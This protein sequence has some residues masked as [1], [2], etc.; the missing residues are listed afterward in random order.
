MFGFEVVPDGIFWPSLQGIIKLPLMT[1]LAV[2]IKVVDP[3]QV[4]RAV[5]EAVAAGAEMLELRLDYLARPTPES[6]RKAVSVA[7]QAGRPG[8]ATCRPL[9][10]GGHFKESEQQ[11][12]NLLAPAV[13][14]GAD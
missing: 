2:P 13:K 5:K 8:I 12:Q 7:R 10:E 14:A 6:A 3:D 4:D 9:W 11:R 1:Y